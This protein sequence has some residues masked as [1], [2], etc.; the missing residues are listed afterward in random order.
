MHYSHAELR[1]RRID[2]WYIAPIPRSWPRRNEAPQNQRG[3][4][5]KLWKCVWRIR[6]SERQS[7]DLMWG[8]D[9]G[10]GPRIPLLRKLPKGLR[11]QRDVRWWGKRLK[12]HSQYSNRKKAVRE[13]LILIQL[14]L[15]L[16][17]TSQEKPLGSLRCFEDLPGFEEMLL[18]RIVLPSSQSCV[19]L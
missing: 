9:W 6:R 7:R 4:Q 2:R 17:L 5:R 11:S 3:N 13:I 10:W 14:V 18:I 8:R 12:S 1:R 15:L 19:H 16:A